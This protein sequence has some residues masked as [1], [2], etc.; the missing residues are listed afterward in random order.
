MHDQLCL[1]ICDP[2]DC[3]PLC[4]SCPWKLLGKNTEVVAISYSRRSS[5]PSDQTWIS[6]I[7]RLDSL[8]LSHLGIA[9][10]FSRYIIFTIASHGTVIWTATL[11]EKSLMLG[12]TEGR[13]EEL[14]EDEMAGWCHWCN[15]H[16]LGQTL[17]DG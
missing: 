9:P 3:S 8:P 11:L 10:P 6:C 12:E 16:E 1:N 15:G 5:Q 17:G 14:S 4:S 2:M 7:G 13:G